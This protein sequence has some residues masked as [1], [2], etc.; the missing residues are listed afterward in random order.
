MIQ[1]ID[2]G[3]NNL[4]SLLTALSGLVQGEVEIVTEASKIRQD[5]LLVIPG[6]GAFGEAMLRLNS[7]ELS[8][9]IVERSAAESG[10]TL[11]ICLGMHLLGQNSEESPTVA[12]LGLVDGSTFRLVPVANLSDR[13]PRVGW[14]SV[15]RG[16][17]DDFHD[18]SIDNGQDFY[19]SHSYHLVLDPD[20]PA[21]T[22]TSPFGSSKILVGFRSGLIAGCQF[23]P[24]KSS[25]N[26]LALLRDFLNWSHEI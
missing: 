18:F 19:F 2:L 10:F 14:E 20:F 16:F 26:G 1:V 4:A 23:H 24:E 5:G 6:T 8:G 13:V 7:S 17:Q 9:A 21:E 22:F 11:G 12:G 15:V 3:L 25:L